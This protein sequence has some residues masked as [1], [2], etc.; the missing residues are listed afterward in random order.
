MNVFDKLLDTLEK[1]HL[2]PVESSMEIS[3]RVNNLIEAI[4]KSLQNKN[5]NIELLKAINS[6]MFLSEELQKLG[7]YLFLDISLSCN[8]EI[9][10]SLAQEYLLTAIRKSNFSVSFLIDERQILDMLRRKNNIENIKFIKKYLKALFSQYSLNDKITVNDEFLGELLK[11]AFENESCRLI[12]LTLSIFNIS[13]EIYLNILPLIQNF[14]N[15]QD[16]LIA[17]KGLTILISIRDEAVTRLDFSNIIKMKQQLPENLAI[18]SNALLLIAK[19]PNL[20]LLLDENELNEY[21]ESI[22]PNLMINCI[23]ASLLHFDQFSEQYKSKVI[24]V[25]L[26]YIGSTD[27][28]NSKIIIEYSQFIP[29]EDLIQRTDLLTCLLDKIGI[30]IE[31]DRVLVM[32]TLELLML[33]SSQNNIEL[34]ELL[35][36]ILIPKYDDI[37]ELCDNSDENISNA[38]SILLSILDSAQEHQ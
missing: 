37:T 1:M 32:R 20:P 31:I 28:N 5:I 21:I 18:F 19:Y 9:L 15:S 33:A 13:H 3:E 22:D 24:T 34:M 2:N 11:F 25:V 4:H 35:M 26:N 16:I 6:E 12:S 17:I 10:K 38:A 23:Q 29:N 7:C 8:D 27:I 14:L 30:D 36:T